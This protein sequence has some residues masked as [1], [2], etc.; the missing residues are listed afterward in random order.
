MACCPRAR[1]WGLLEGD[2]GRLA[3]AASI[4]TL[5]H[6]VSVTWA[7]GERR[8][9]T[10]L[11][12]ISECSDGRAT[13]AT[14]DPSRE[15][16][17]RAY[18]TCGAGAVGTLAVRG[19]R[20][21]SVSAASRNDPLE[22]ARDH[23]R[24]RRGEASFTFP[25][26]TT[27]CRRCH[28]G[29]GTANT[30]AGGAATPSAYAGRAH[31][32]QVPHPH[33]FSLCFGIDS[34][35]H[36]AVVS[37]ARMFIAK[38]VAGAGSILGKRLP[39]TIR[40]EAARLSMNLETCRVTSRTPFPRTTS[41]SHSRRRRPGPRSSWTYRVWSIAVSRDISSG[42]CDVRCSWIRI[43]KALPAQLRR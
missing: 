18:V 7:S 39:K 21:G 36:Q 25:T 41:G 8:G 16:S 9:E 37:E 28:T 17:K 33:R 24:F 43:R 12:C 5:W 10:I 30:A 6:P 4:P 15:S 22:N 26:A 11:H 20:G 19:V 38:K 34:A 27:R 35:G 2:G 40:P 14:G 42:S 13:I 3:A 29:T 23:R 31:Q 32:Q 1:G